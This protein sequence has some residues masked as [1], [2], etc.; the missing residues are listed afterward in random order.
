ML[1]Q[2]RLKPYVWNKLLYEWEQ[3]FASNFPQ[4]VIEITGPEVSILRNAIWTATQRDHWTSEY[5]AA[6]YKVPD[7][8]EWD[9]ITALVANLE[10]KLMG[11]DNVNLGFNDNVYVEDTQQLGQVNGSIYTAACPAGEVWTIQNANAVCT[12][13]TTN[14]VQIWVQQNGANH[15]ALVEATS[16]PASRQTIYNGN[17]VLHE[18]DRLIAYFWTTNGSCTI[19]IRAFGYKTLV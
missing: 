17:I 4:L 1:E 14:I 16:V 2:E 9:E 18:G 11:N 13:S 12:G 6:G 15:A 19:T 3:D 5:T 7:D 8:T 10:A